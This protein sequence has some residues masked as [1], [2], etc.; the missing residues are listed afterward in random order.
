VLWDLWEHE[1]T[2]SQV[3]TGIESGNSQWLKVAAALR[4]FGDGSASLSL[5]Y[6][7]A[8]ALPKAP[9]AVLS[10]VGHGLE[11]EYICTSPFIEPDPG[12]AEAYERRTLAALSSVKDPALV[13]IAAEC[14][15]GVRLPDGP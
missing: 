15:K 8:I 4:P 13:P 10:M 14:A 3:L 2:F 1:S 9:N 6:A 5:D 7:V 11:A 12:V